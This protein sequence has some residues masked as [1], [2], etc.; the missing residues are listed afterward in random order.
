[1][2][3]LPTVRKIEE[4]L[5]QAQLDPR[6]INI[7]CQIAERQRVQHEQIYAFAKLFVQLQEKFEE[8]LKAL[9]VRDSNLKK[10]GIEE[11]M[12]GMK[13]DTKN[14]GAEVGSVEQFDEEESVHNA[15]RQKN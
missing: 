9:G 2:A 3:A 1:M 13:G 7:V 12:K 5:R 6:L 4:T 14:L 8:T 15:T 10:L 11:M